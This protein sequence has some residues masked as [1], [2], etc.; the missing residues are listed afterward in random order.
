MRPG[1]IVTIGVQIILAVMVASATLLSPAAARSAPE[2][3]SPLVEKL[4]PA[5]VNIST[6]QKV[7]ANEMGGQMLPFPEMP[8]GPGLEEFRDFMERFGNPGGKPGAKEQE[9][10]SLGSGFIID[11]SGFVV[12]NHHVIAKSED[13]TVILSDNTKL[14]ATVVG[15]DSKTDLALLKVTA[16]KPLPFVSFGNSDDTKVGD[17]VIAIGN[18]FGLGGSVSA[19][20]VSARQRN[21]NAGPFDDFIQTDAAINRGNSGGPLFNIKGEVIGINSAIFSPSGG[22][23]GIGFAVPS[24]LASPIIKQLKEFGRTQRGWL[25]VKIQ[26]VTDE[27]AES[28]GLGKARGA[29]VLD[30]T[31]E[32]PAGKAG[33]KAGDVITKFDGADIKEMRVLPRRVAETKI[34]REVEVEVWRAGKNL[35]MNI[36]VAEL[37]E[38]EEAVA[39][40]APAEGRPKGA[41]KTLEVMGIEVAALNDSLRQQYGLSEKTKGLLVISVKPESAAAKQDIRE[42]DMVIQ[43]GEQLTENPEDFDAAIQSVRKAGRKNALVRIEREGESVFI[44]LP[45]VE[46]KK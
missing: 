46:P 19:G 17:W 45:T 1:S 44:T 9:V 30:V 32:S 5:V 11:A 21:I 15:S 37:D 18:P 12:T 36:T 29:L 16:E 25:G 40:D 10:F 35:K 6:T 3:F 23:V 2:S 31:A 34:G 24:G 7:S 41:G 27:M 42:G 8:Q 43:V 33:I 38:S 28:L 14:K 20:I 13:I 39:T 4:I 22:N 26:E